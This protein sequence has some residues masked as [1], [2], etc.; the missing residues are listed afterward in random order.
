M[1]EKKNSP[2]YDLLQRIDGRLER[3]EER[4][5]QIERK[6]V[7]YGSAAGALAGGLVACGLAVARLKLGI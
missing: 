6:A 4:F 2:E 1:T 7:L 5:P 3:F